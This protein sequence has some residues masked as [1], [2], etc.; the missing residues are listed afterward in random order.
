LL[1]EV[2][3][4]HRHHQSAPLGALLYACQTDEKGRELMDVQINGTSI[5][6]NAKS[7]VAVAKR[8]AAHFERRIREDDWLP[9][10]T[11]QDALS[12]WRR[13]G[14]IRVKVLAAYNLI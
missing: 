10:K 14:G 6:V 5:R 4:R 2:D 11:K 8:I 9:Y 13:L 1:A 12:T 7:D 3:S